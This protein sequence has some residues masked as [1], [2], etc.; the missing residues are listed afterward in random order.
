MLRRM[1]P[2]EKADYIPTSDEEVRLYE[3]N[4]AHW[5]YHVSKEIW[6]KSVTAITGV[7]PKGYGFYA[8]LARQGSLEN[9]DQEKDAGGDR[10]SAFHSGAVEMQTGETIRQK[11]Y[12]PDAWEHLI[13]LKAWH[14]KY[15]PE[16]IAIESVVYN[17][18]RRVAGT[19]DYACYLDGVPTIIDYKT[20]KYIYESARIQSDQYGWLWNQ[21]GREPKIEQVGVVRTGS[22]HKC[23]YE[24]WVEPISERRKKLFNCLHWIQHDF[25]PTMEPKFPKEP[26]KELSLESNSALLNGDV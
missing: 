15:Q 22:K 12:P 21:L 25:D 18:R 10:G 24:F 9:A 2:P 8:W 3:V 13:S 19:L 11:D 6:M 4:D 23:G 14:D 16:N 1:K 26:P 7:Y 17:L 5:Y 20:S